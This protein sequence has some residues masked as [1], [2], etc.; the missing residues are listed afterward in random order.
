MNKRFNLRLIVLV[1]TDIVIIYG[2]ILAALFFR[3]GTAGAASQ[4]SE[5]FGWLKITLATLICLIALHF[6]DL[7][8]YAVIHNR[9]ELAVRLTQALGT[10]WCL[11]ALIFY[12]APFVR[13][14]PGT[15]IFSVIITLA[16]LLLL[17]TWIHYFT[18][19]PEIGEK[20]VIVGDGKIALD[21]AEAVLE[22]R[23]AGFRIAGYITDDFETIQRKLPGARYLG[24]IL[25]LEEALQRQKIDRIVISAN[26]RR[27]TFPAK[28]LM[29]ISLAGDTSIEEGTSFY[30]RITGRVHLDMVRPS[31]LIFSGRKRE[32]RFRTV[33]RR[34]LNRFLALT[35]LIVS[36]PLAVLT[37]VLIKLDSKGDL[38]YR[39]ER[40]GKNGRL[41][42]VIKFR[43]MKTDAEADGKPVWALEEDDRVTRVG[44]VIR[45]LRIDEIP[46]FWNILK[47]EMSFVGPRPERPHF[48]SQLSEEIPFYEYRHLVTPGL[49][50]WAQIKYPYGASVEDARQKLQF[51]LYY[52]K[53]QTLVLDLIIFFE[54]IKI[55]IFG[56]GAR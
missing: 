38:F 27:G 5:H 49:T 9:R 53:N 6:F 4:L 11:L 34:L 18:G 47:G 29:R 1:F 10:A 45:K 28:T 56:R 55:I 37:A 44:R 3:L 17:R 36:L 20:I 21:T 13:L 30:E 52:I 26:G 8:D 19:H 7:Y 15:S 54:T 46:Q 39:Q 32:T 31:W 25:D 48:V 50:G 24:D 12:F 35:G 2:G 51:D 22:R 43:S 40:V 33:M 42:E 23:D 41:F 14:G 16:L